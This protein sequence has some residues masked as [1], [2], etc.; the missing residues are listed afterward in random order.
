MEYNKL[1]NQ[2][3][4]WIKEGFIGG[5]AF[6]DFLMMKELGVD[7]VY[8]FEDELVKEY[9][10][11]LKN[12]LETEQFSLLL[13]VTT[14]LEQCYIDNDS[15]IFECFSDEIYEHYKNS[16]MIYPLQAI[17]FIINTL[18][19]LYF[20]GEYTQLSHNLFILKRT[21]IEIWGED[22]YLFCKNWCH[23]LFEVMVYFLPDIAIKEFKQ[24]QDIFSK[25][26]KDEVVLYHL[27]LKIGDMEAKQFI[28]LG[29]KKNSI[30]LCK[31][32][33]T[34]SNKKNQV[35]ILP[36]IKI[37]S[38]FYNRNI[39]QYEDAISDLYSV[40]NIINNKQLKLYVYIQIGTILYCKNDL[41]S[42]ENLLFDIKKEMGLLRVQNEDVAEFHNL[43]GLYYF[44]AGEYEKAIEEI[45]KS[46]SIESAISENITDNILKFKNNILTIRMAKGEYINSELNELLNIALKNPNIYTNSL[47]LLLNLSSYLE[48]I[49]IGFGSGKIYRQIKTIL[50]NNKE[51]LDMPSIIVLKC[52]KYYLNLLNSDS[53]DSIEELRNELYTF[54]KHNPRTDGYFQFLEGE[55]LWWSKKD[56]K[57]CSNVLR[58]IIEYFSYIN[59]R[60]TSLEYFFKL[61]V[62][63]RL[64]LWE[65]KYSLAK[66]RL[67]DFWKSIIMPLFKTL[68]NCKDSIYDNILKLLRSYASFYISAAR[69]YP[70]LL[71]TSKELY[72]FVLNFK[73][74]YFK[75]LSNS[76]IAD[77]KT[78]VDRWWTT[79]DI[80]LENHNLLIE[81]FEYRNYQLRDD[82]KILGENILNIDDSINQICFSIRC[83]KL[84]M[85]NFFEVNI[86][87]DDMVTK[88][89]NRIADAIQSE[90]VSEFEEH[91][92]VDITKDN[93]IPNTIYICSDF[94]QIHTPAAILRVSDN[95]FWGDI[96]NIIY[97]NTGLDICN[98][99]KII[100]FTKSIF[101]GN[102]QFENNSFNKSKKINR[103]INDLYFAE[104]EVS[105]LGKLTGGLVKLNQQSPRDKNIWKGMD[106]IH[107]ATHSENI[108]ENSY[109]KKIMLFAKNEKGVYTNLST[110]DIST[111]DWNNV[112]LVVFSACET[113]E[114]IWKNARKRSFQLSA[115]EAGAH[116]SISTFTQTED[117]DNAFFMVCLYKN[118]IK[119]GSICDAYF[120]TQ[121]MMKT[122]TKK[123]ILSDPDY[124]NTGMQ[125][126]LKNYGENDTP[127]SENYVWALYLLQMNGREK[128][129]S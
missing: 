111:F 44:K 9:I 106:I 7:I 2:K 96:S 70:E 120:Q 79:E 75:Y 21:Y 65:K 18:Q 107:F 34:N 99:E 94:Y 84:G 73:F 119:F 95:L 80:M 85:A 33:Y 114:A 104:L 110:E 118:L 101:Y 81:C 63:V 15:E 49:D 77:I 17:G 41:D 4:I 27:C 39:G 62:N 20:L 8:N 6:C 19:A 83:K 88:I 24:Y 109:Q 16:G 14:E 123:Q 69:Q 32:W 26:L 112:K 23:I 11:L 127:F 29:Y 48:S 126:Y 61:C 5:A 52:N 71:I 35:D 124:I 51:I 74:L 86:L 45:E 30:E 125:E 67:N 122:L 60:N 116:F 121:K 105:V 82:N 42:L 97:C 25:L 36:I 57:E 56:K 100:D 46:I 58:Q 28:D 1:K 12:R 31:S 40:V 102:S 128:Y 117:G 78:N 59:P 98:D 37:A 68:N 55:F 92:W 13:L 66:K 72:E 43:F 115:K 129:E 38:A 103:S 93:Y 10:Y 54:F 3:D 50:D 22:S 91:A 90:H 89:R 64:A 53:T 87:I 113:D 108:S 76:Q 47:P